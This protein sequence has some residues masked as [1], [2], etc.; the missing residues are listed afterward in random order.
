VVQREMGRG[1][2]EMGL[3]ARR[4]DL[5]HLDRAYDCEIDTST[6]SPETC[7]AAIREV[8]E[9]RRGRAFDL[10]RSARET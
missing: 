2:R 3:A 9:G 7:A 10:M 1:D 8:V 4:F 6:M 5:V